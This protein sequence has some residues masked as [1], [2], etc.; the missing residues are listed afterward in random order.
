MEMNGLWMCALVACAL[1]LALVAPAGLVLGVSGRT[2]SGDGG[3]NA[4]AAIQTAID[5]LPAAGG[6]VRLTAPTYVLA[7]G[8]ASGSRYPSGRP[9]RSAIVVRGNHVRILGNAGRSILEL[10]P[11]AKM[12]AITI[13]GK[14]DTLSG[15]SVHGDGRRRHPGNGWPGGDVVDALVY[16]S[17]ARDLTITHCDISDGIEDGI[18]AFDTDGIT[19]RD[20]TIHDNGTAIAGAVGIAFT[21]TTRAVATGNRIDRNSAAGISVDP[22][23]K[24]V[25]INADAIDGNDK[26]GIIVAG[27][28]V[29]VTGNAVKAN[30]AA[31]HAAI[32][33]YGANATTVSDN[34][35]VDNH[36]FGIAVENG[37][38]GPGRGITL[39]ANTVTGNGTSTADQIHIAPGEGVNSSWRSA[40]T[41]RLD[42]QAGW[43]PLTAVVI[44]GAVGV[45]GAGVDRWRAGRA[46]DVR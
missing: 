27:S 3:T 4:A 46:A 7:S 10:A 43:W 35:V 25:R 26:E 19:V 41:I 8:S 33:L 31:H 17:D 40:N 34:T 29:T 2:A 18:G 30:G 23:S 1:P 6:T 21:D 44:A 38:R 22:T 11:G 13:T 32:S 28:R 37:K 5:A 12:R 15:I 42:L 45:V 39:A 9:I 20:S 16:A 14:H 24:S 36:Y